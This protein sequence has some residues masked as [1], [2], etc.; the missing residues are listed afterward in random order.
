MRSCTDAEDG[1]GATSCWW[2]P[3]D[4]STPSAYGP[5]GF[6]SIT[7]KTSA[8]PQTAC[9]RGL[10]A[11][12]VVVSVSLESESVDQLRRRTDHA[13]SII[14]VGRDDGERDSARRSGADSFL[15]ATADVLYEIHRALILRR[16][17][18][19]LAVEVIR[20]AVT[21]LNIGC[22]CDLPP[23]IRHA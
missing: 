20:C 23:L 2:T 19:P 5:P 13:T 8:A 22:E 4:S 3:S 16:S 12:V 6:G 7:S 15:L 9:P 18:R 1:C 17:G 11:D 10:P 21:L 14:I